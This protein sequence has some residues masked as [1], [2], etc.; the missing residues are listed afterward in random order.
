MLKIARLVSIAI[1]LTALALRLSIAA[2]QAAR[3]AGRPSAKHQ[4]PIQDDRGS[5]RRAGVGSASAVDPPPDSPERGAKC[6]V[7]EQIRRTSA[8]RAQR[9]GQL[10][11]AAKATTP[12]PPSASPSKTVK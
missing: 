9:R 4:H 2:L 10:F 5:H 7:V 8:A 1:L 6:T 3:D 11:K 12:L